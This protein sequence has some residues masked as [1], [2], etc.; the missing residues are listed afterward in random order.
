M[1]SGVTP[2]RSR[3]GRISGKM[4][5]MSVLYPIARDAE[6]ALAAPLGRAARA[7][8]ARE[9]TS[10]EVEFIR[11]L[12]GPAFE[13]AQAGLDAYV[14][15]LDAEGRAAIAPEDRFCDLVEVLEPRAGR[16]KSQDRPRLQAGGQAEPVFKA[17]HR[18]PQPKRLLKTVWRLSV[19]YWRTVEAGRQAEI[20]SQARAARRSAQAEA[21]D[22]ASLRAMA[23]QPLRPVKAQQPLDIGLFEVRLPDAPHIIMPDE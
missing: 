6:A 23:E 20:A 15:L 1:E 14:G 22:P 9:M 4:R 21:L 19:S 12:T 5:S 13:T 8:D 16:A 11:E 10:G 7:S 2:Q 18:W 17:G 3:P